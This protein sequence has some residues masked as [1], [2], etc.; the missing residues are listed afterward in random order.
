MSENPRP[1][2]EPSMDSAGSEEVEPLGRREFELLAEDL[3]RETA[4]RVFAVVQELGE[5]E[6]GVVAARGLAFEDRAEVV[7]TEGVSRL[8]ARTP[9]S[10]LRFFSGAN[11]SR[12]RLIWLLDLS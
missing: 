12:A 7:L 9:E 3:V 5:R 10:A 6:D 2:D 8:S 4:P 11:G 1:A